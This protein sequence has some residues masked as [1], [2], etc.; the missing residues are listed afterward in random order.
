MKWESSKIITA[1]RLGAQWH[2]V[3]KD[4][5]PTSASTNPEP[6]LLLGSEITQSGNTLH[7][8]PAPGI[9]MVVNHC[10]RRAPRQRLF[11]IPLTPRTP[12]QEEVGVDS[13]IRTSPT[14][15]GQLEVTHVSKAGLIFFV[16][17]LPIPWTSRLRY[18]AGVTHCDGTLYI[19]KRP[20]SHHPDL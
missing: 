8:S 10:V 3:T 7:A 15:R 18:L 19:D 17:S 4:K 11:S 2:R 12:S 14:D 9:M 1:F 20:P 5:T 6:C 16:S 13:K